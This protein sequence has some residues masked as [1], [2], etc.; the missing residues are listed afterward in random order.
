METKILV[1]EDNINVVQEIAIALENLGYKNVHTAIS[2]DQA[3]DIIESTF[4]DIAILDI[5][6]ADDPHAGIKIARRLNLI[7]RIPIIYMSANPEDK[8]LTYEVRPNAFIEKPN[9]VNVFHAL[10]MAIRN[11]ND[12]FIDGEKEELLNEDSIYIMKNKVLCRVVK[13][14]VLYTRAEGGCIFIHTINGE[15]YTYSSTL[16][17]FAK[18]MN[19]DKFVKLQRSFYIN[20]RFIDSFDKYQLNIKASEIIEIPLTE[21][22]YNFLIDRVN[23]FK[24]K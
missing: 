16:K 1:F 4:P 20:T 8:A 15:C 9:Y 21:K 7:R 3:F 12:V 22:G 19:D 24:S 2:K 11:F 17:Q 23:R 5:R 18:Y 13:K 6:G 14:E 10:D